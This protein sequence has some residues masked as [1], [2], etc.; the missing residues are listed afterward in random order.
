[1]S[2]YSY[3]IVPTQTNKIFTTEKGK[4][5]STFA[6]YMLC[7]GQQS[8]ADLGYSP[9]PMNLV[10]AGFDQIAKIPAPWAPRISEN[11]TT[12]RSSRVTRR[13]TTSSP[14][15]RRTRRLRQAG[16]EPVPGRYRR[17]AGGDTQTGSGGVPAAAPEAP[18]ARR[19]TGRPGA[20]RQPLPRRPR[21]RAGTP[22]TTRTATSSRE[23]RRPEEP[24]RCPR[25]SRWREPVGHAAIH[26][27]R[28][29]CPGRGGDPGAA[30]DVSPL[31]RDG[32]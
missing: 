18:P 20:T 11:A 23:P 7:E 24:P 6:S 10:Q 26:H 2:S 31:R 30:A 17:R 13:R 15:P 22:S 9:L 1:M 28:G 3:M 21:R 14:S 19:R 4:T 12:P 5:L 27:A 8:A 29:R 16:T 32:S 25:P